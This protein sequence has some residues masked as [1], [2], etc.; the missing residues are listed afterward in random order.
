MS[1]FTVDTEAV[2]SATTAVRGTSER[3]QAEAS[4]MMGQLTGLQS[5]WTG[6]A[7]LACQN[8]AE[9]WRSAQAHVEQALATIAQ[10]LNAAGQQYA[11]AEDYSASLFH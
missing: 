6:G 8:A 2:F 4:T 7:A 9:Q 3:L 10:A 1:V 11:Q 5:S